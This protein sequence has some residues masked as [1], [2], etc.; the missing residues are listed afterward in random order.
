[1]PKAT[2][3]NKQSPKLF[4]GK[5]SMFRAETNEIQM[6]KKSNRKDQ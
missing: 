5:K 3:K 6:K 2:K 1:M 4:E